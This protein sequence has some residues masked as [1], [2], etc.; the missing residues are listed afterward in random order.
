MWLCMHI[1]FNKQAIDVLSNSM[2]LFKLRPYYIQ[3]Y[4]YSNLNV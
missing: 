3:T 4:L 2:F 1:Y